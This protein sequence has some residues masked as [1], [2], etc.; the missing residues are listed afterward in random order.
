MSKIDEELVERVALLIADNRARCVRSWIDDEPSS[1]FIDPVEDGDRECASAAIAALSTP[2]FVLP[3]AEEMLRA[4]DA[5]SV[6]F[7]LTAYDDMPVALF[8]GDNGNKTRLAAGLLD[9]Y[10]AAKVE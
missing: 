5:T 10:R 2:E 8:V 4:V 9:A 7:E 1:D 3:L 6:D